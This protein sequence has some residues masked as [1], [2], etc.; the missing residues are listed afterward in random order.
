MSIEAAESR[1]DLSVE[2]ATERKARVQLD[3]DRI[4]TDDGVG[5]LLYWMLKRHMVRIG[6]Q[7]A[8]DSTIPLMSSGVWYENVFLSTLRWTGADG[9][10]VFVP[11][12]VLILSV[13]HVVSRER[14]G[15]H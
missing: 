13:G 6:V 2:E 7:V 4:A 11:Y 5:R 8:I 9:T 12:L 1:G 14:M 10:L 3:A 15:V